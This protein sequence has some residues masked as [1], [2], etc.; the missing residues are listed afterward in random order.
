MMSTEFSMNNDSHAMTVGQTLRHARESLGLTIR[1]MA[2]ITR[3]QN[4]WLECIEHD[5]YDEMPAEVFI[6]GFLRNYTR[7]L[8]LDED[9]IFDQYLAQTGQLRAIA[10]AD[11]SESATVQRFAH[12]HLANRSSSARYLYFAAAAAMIALL[13]GAILAVST[14]AEQD[15][16]AS[17]FRVNDTTD[18][19]QPALDNA[20]DWRRQ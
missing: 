6:R 19:W 8:R 3:I 11:V 14:G 10:P 4:V 16:A 13:A 5:R 1:D 18:A 15:T 9:V 2:E 12:A 17:N 7:E 20:S